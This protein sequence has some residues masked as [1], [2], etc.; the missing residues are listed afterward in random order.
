MPVFNVDRRENYTRQN[1]SRAWR[2]NL[3]MTRYQLTALYGNWSNCTPKQNR[4]M[5]KA[6]RRGDGSL[7]MF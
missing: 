1:F 3:V 7:G 2:G 5:R 6:A 4:R